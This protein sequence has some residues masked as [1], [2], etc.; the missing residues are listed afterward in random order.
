MSLPA[1]D[2]L[3]TPHAD[4]CPS[5]S[6]SALYITSVW[7]TQKTLFPV[8]LPLS[9]HV[10][11]VM[12]PCLPSHCL[13]MAAPSGSTIITFSHYVIVFTYRV[14][15]SNWYCNGFWWWYITLEI[16][17]FFYYIHHLLFSRA[18]FRNWICFCPQV[19]GRTALILLGPLERANPFH[20]TGLIM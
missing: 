2:C 6:S 12:E 14:I 13:A 5:C 19:K 9:C 16:T 3:A 20:W 1:G 10:F 18:C 17:E 11:I 15:E 8:I 4:N 7:T